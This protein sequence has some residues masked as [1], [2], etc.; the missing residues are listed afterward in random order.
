VVTAAMYPPAECNFLIDVRFVDLTA[1]MTAH[2]G[3]RYM[4]CLRFEC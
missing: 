1:I 3:S 4:W 2:T